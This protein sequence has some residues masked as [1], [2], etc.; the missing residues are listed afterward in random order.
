MDFGVNLNKINML[1]LFEMNKNEFSFERDRNWKI[2]CVETEIFIEKMV[3]QI[4]KSKQ[5]ARPYYEM[6]RYG[7]NAILK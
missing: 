1:K 6:N 3:E 7:I 4:K 2:N 5:F